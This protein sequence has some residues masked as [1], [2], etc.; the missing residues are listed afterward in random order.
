MS[1][2]TV[3]S[4]GRRRVLIMGL[5]GAALVAGGAGTY[6]AGAGLLWKPEF[7]GDALT[8]VQAL[9]MAES[10]A[11]T[12]VDIRRPDEWAKTGIGRPANPLDMRRE[13]F[14][15]ALSSLV[16]GQRDA[17]VAIICAR[18]VRS[19]RLARALDEAGFTRIIDVPEG[20][21]GSKAGPGWLAR[22]LP[23]R[24]PS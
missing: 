11:I 20:M 12:L 24:A 19:A 22:D 15:A 7:E 6:V 14:I 1:E 3:E 18:G 2:H 5:A 21:L 13:D 8:P 16:D 10:G 9:E 17:P 4:M 23:T